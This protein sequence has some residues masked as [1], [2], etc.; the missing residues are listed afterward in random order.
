M[1][2][3]GLGIDSVEIERFKEWH[4]YSHK[5]LR[6]IFSET[7]IAYCLATPA[8]SAERFAARFAVREAFLKA[9]HQAM[10]QYKIPLLTICKAIEIVKTANSAPHM[11]IDRKILNI[12]ES[13]SFNCSVSWTHTRTVATAIVLIST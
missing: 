8:K 7:E 5:S 9:L 6:R 10:P 1:Q 12:E 11:I 13:P 3:V 2:T 4:T